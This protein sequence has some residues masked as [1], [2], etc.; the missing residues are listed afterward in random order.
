MKRSMVLMLVLVMLFSGSTGCSQA[1]KV[2]ATQGGISEP[3]E[4]IGSIEVERQVPRIA[5]R[6]IFGQLWEWITF[7]R[8]ENISREAYLQGLLNKK[9]LKAA[10]N[11]YNAEAVIHTEYW[12][13]LTEKKFPQ[14]RV[15]AKGDMVRYKRFPV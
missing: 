1:H 3:S 8:S 6:R 7:G 5:Y 14:G 11:V 15:Y 4:S 13:D 10:K 12:P 9:M 2:I